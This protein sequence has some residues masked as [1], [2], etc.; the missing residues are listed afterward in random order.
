MVAE[1]PWKTYSVFEG[2]CLP[3]RCLEQVVGFFLLKD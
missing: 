2:M 3:I 1:M